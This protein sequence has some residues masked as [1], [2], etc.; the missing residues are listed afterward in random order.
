MQV[1]QLRFTHDTIR[2]NFRDGRPLWQLLNDLN[3]GAV[4]PLRD[5]EPLRVVW[6]AGGWRSLSNRRLWALK[7]YMSTA[8]REVWVRVHVAEADAEFH[9]KNTTKNNGLSVLVT[10]RSRSVSPVSAAGSA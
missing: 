8:G 2:P 7:S 4:D 5:L 9:A 3:A 10:A 1:A 6:Y